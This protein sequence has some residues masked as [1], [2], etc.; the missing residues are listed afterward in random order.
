MEIYSYC[1]AKITAIICNINRNKYFS[2]FTYPYWLVWISN[3]C[4]PTTSLYCIY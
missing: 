4:T 2:L 1:F 3:F